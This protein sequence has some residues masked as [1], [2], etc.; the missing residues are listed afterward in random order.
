MEQVLLGSPHSA[1]ADMPNFAGTWKM[2]SSKNF[3]EL[4][5]ALGKPRLFSSLSLSLFL[6][7]LREVGYP[8]C[9]YRKRLFLFFEN[10]YA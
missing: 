2:K 3:D 9:P 6:S 5:K 10:W 4:L 1:S 7:S 8:S